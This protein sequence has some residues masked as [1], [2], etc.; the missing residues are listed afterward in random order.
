MEV[1]LSHGYDHDV[2]TIID[3]FFNVDKII[4]KNRS[5]GCKNLEV[6]HCERQG[7]SGKIRIS[8]D[9]APSSEV[10]STLKA[11]QKERNRVTQTEHW[12]TKA[13]GSYFCEYKVEIE[14]VPAELNGQMHVVPQGDSAI[15]NVSLSIKCKIPLL[16]K[17]ISGFIAKDSRLQMEAEYEIIKQQLIVD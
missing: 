14:G 1:N 12:S 3:H 10:P 15:N 4:E 17:V 16:G 6:E 9:I 2:E 5:L 8:R 7:S 11:F 13:D